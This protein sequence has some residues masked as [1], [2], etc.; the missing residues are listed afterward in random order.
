MAE[1]KQNGKKETKH[2]NNAEIKNQKNKLKIRQK[3]ETTFL[4]D[5]RVWK[6]KNMEEQTRILRRM[7]DG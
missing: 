1:R 4:G 7:V 2:V 6:L 5:V 3:R